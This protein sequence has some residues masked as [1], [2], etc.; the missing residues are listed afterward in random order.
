[1]ITEEIKNAFISL[2]CALSP[3]NLHCDGEIS[4]SQ[5]QRKYNALMK[6]W[7]AL[8]KKIG[9]QVDEYEVFSW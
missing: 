7:R 5:A 4:R 2:A 9:R 3:E 1:M 8:E 6:K